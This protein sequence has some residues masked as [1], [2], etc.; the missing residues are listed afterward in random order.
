MEHALARPCEHARAATTY[1]RRA[2]VLLCTLALLGATD[3]HA[4]NLV[5]VGD[6]PHVVDLETLLHPTAPATVAQA[7]PHTGMLPSS[8]TRVGDDADMSGLAGTTGRPM[9]VRV[10]R[11]AHVGRDRI[12]LAYDRAITPPLHNAPMVGRRT[13]AACDHVGEIQRGFAIAYDAVLAHRDALC[14]EAS[15]LHGFSRRRVCFMLRPA[16]VY[17]SLHDRLSHPR[18]MRDGADR[19]IEIDRLA[20]L[21]ATA[22]ADHWW[23]L[24]RAEHAALE[25]GDVPRFRVWTNGEGIEAH[26][27]PPLTFVGEA[28]RDQLRRRLQA[29][30]PADR[31]AGVA[32]IAALLDPASA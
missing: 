25:R 18:F 28:P 29:M 24:V 30:S 2:G 10:G 22:A 20:A 6:H 17:G 27:E 31:D 3:M 8:A 9:W 14:G 1:Y 15:P 13:L 26:G 11:W 23:P 5:A 12:E 4:A 16:Q 21:A 7:L 32:A 19:S